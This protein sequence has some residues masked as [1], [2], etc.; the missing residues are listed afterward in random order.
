MPNIGTLLP[1]SLGYLPATSAIP[2][3]KENHVLSILISGKMDQKTHLV[4]HHMGTE[5]RRLAEKHE[6]KMLLTIAHIFEKGFFSQKYREKWENLEDF[7]NAAEPGRGPFLACFQPGYT[8]AFGSAL[9][10]LAQ[11]ENEKT[12]MARGL[13]SRTN[14]S[15]EPLLKHRAAPQQAL[16]LCQHPPPLP[17]RR[18][19]AGGGGR[20]G[21]RR[22]AE[23]DGESAEGVR[24]G[25]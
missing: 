24:G 23:G 2:G 21:R 17:R 11:G 14:M 9:A 6:D 16:R 8:H 1:E 12:S 3:K 18:R 22:L 7:S 5:M 4:F 25:G 13:N 20:R 19:S 10:P 15:R